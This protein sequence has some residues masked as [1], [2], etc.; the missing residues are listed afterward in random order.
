MV[1]TLGT[2]D[3]F[4][5]RRLSRPTGSGD[6]DELAPFYLKT[7]IGQGLD[8][9]WI[10]LVDLKEL[11]HETVFMHLRAIVAYYSGECK[12]EEAGE[13]VRCLRIRQ[14]SVTL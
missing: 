9:A 4:Q 5:Q 6:E 1:R 14:I 12:A 2:D 3:Q 11:N 13:A 10:C 7:D 8:I